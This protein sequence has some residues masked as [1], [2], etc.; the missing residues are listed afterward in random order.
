MD[1]VVLVALSD[2]EPS[3]AMLMVLDFALS[4]S[5]DWFLIPVSMDAWSL[6]QP[7]E[8]AVTDVFGDTTI[9]NHPFGRWNLFRLEAQGVNRTGLA[10]AYLNASP[11]ESIEGPPLEELHL[12]KDETANVAWAVERL[13]PHPLNHS[14]EPPAPRS[15][16]SGTAISGLSW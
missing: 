4:Y 3:P 1:Q 8:I 16:G 14:I 12:L 6:F 10:F 5:D 15:S 7:T 9:A 2:T 13:V 11:A